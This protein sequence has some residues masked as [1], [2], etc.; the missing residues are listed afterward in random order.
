[1]DKKYRL[2]KS[3]SIEREGRILYRIKALRSFGNVK[4]GYL[5]GYIEKEENLSQNDD[6]AWV[7]TDGFVL[8]DAVVR[9]KAMIVIGEV[10][11]GEVIGG[12]IW[13]CTIRG[14]VIKGGVLSGGIVTGGVISGGEVY[15][16][17][18]KG[19][20]V[21][22]GVI[23]GGVISGGEIKAGVFSG[24]E[25]KG[26]IFKNSTFQVQGSYH[27]LNISRPNHIKIGCIERTFDYWKKHY[28]AIGDS[29]GYTPE[30]IEEYGRYIDL[31]ISFP[32]QPTEENL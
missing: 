11:G 28:K 24:G 4:K 25:I 18:V 30:Q 1:M 2:L 15:G 19:G 29:E 12:L 16:G 21:S 13:G 26:G 10:S 5:G 27:L 7:F 31:A 9:S 32:N 6:L 14:G 8:G 3:Q 17:E 20:I 22:G 23:Y